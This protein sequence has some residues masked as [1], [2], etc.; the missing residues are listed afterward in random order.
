LKQ[1]IFVEKWKPYRSPLFK[2][3]SSTVKSCLL[4]RNNFLNPTFSNVV[5][6]CRMFHFPPI[7]N[8]FSTKSI[9]MCTI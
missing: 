3:L 8:I 5:L 4:Y 6:R 1:K 9:L 7:L 2:L